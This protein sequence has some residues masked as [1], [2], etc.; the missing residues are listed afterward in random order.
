MKRKVR[1]QFNKKR[2]IHTVRRCFE[3]IADPKSSRGF[4]LVDSL[5]SRFAVFSL[6]YPSLLDFDQTIRNASPAVLANMKRL[7]FI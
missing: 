5:M 1:K 6:K 3:Q 4:T 7:L 2:L